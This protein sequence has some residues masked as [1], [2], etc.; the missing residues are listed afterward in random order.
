ML[1]QILGSRKFNIKLT[2]NYNT[3]YTENDNIKEHYEI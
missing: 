3:M 1:W 2:I